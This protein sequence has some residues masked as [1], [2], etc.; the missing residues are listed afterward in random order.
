MIYWLIFAL[1]FLFFH[2]LV[3]YMVT[4]NEKIITIC[5]KFKV[6]INGNETLKF[7]GRC[8]CKSKCKSI[9]YDNKE[10]EYVISEDILISNKRCNDLWN[11]I[12]ENKTYKIKYYGFNV[13]LIDCNYKVVDIS[14]KIE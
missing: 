6:N 7:V 13:S 2:R 11:M 3:Y 9:Q 14:E 8:K 1:V 12:I 10:I 4:S 5:H